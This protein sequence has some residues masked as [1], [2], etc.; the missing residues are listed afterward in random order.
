VRAQKFDRGAHVLLLADAVRVRAGRRAHATKVEA[1]RDDATGDQGLGGAVDDVVVH[2]AAT[3]RVRMTDDRRRDG[4]RRLAQD[5]FQRSVRDGDRH[6]PRRRNRCRH[7]RLPYH[8][9]T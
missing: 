3:T 9:I 2:R 4:R 6:P 1:Q 7:S 5:P 8:L